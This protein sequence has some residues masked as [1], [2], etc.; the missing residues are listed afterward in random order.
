MSPYR[1]LIVE[2]ET[3]LLKQLKKLIIKEGFIVDIAENGKKALE[4]WENNI[5]DLVLL[6]LAMPKMNGREVLNRIKS[7]QP[8]TQI[9]II[10]GQGGKDDLIDAINKH[11]YKYI[12][13]INEKEQLFNDIK[14]SVKSALENRHPLLLSLESMIEKGENETFLLSGEETF[15]PKKLYDEVRKGTD[16]GKQFCKDFEKSI[17]EFT[18]IEES[19]DDLLGIKGVV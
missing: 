7:K 11:V 1:I 5:Y 6:D 17:K 18:P 12:E 13:K 10:S 14:M 15:T 3:N 2:D 8:L 19:I 16:F 9:V 4:K